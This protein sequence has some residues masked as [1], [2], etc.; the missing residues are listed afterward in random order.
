MLINTPNFV[1]FTK[2][3]DYYKSQG[4]EELTPAEINREIQ[5]LI[6]EGEIYL[7]KPEQ[8]VQLAEA[9]ILHTNPHPDWFLA[10]LVE[11]YFFARRNDDAVAVIEKIPDSELNEN[12]AAAI[13]DYACAGKLERARRHAERYLAELRAG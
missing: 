12:R 5:D 8:A 13:C 6:D 9:T 11:A 10:D 1:N 2:A 7:G 4:M 3:C